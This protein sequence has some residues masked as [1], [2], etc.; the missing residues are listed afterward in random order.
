MRP[1]S[2]YGSLESDGDG[3]EHGGDTESGPHS[4]EPPEPLE[5][6]AWLESPLDRLHPEQSLA[7]I[8]KVWCFFI[9]PLTRM[10]LVG[11]WGGCWS[12]S[13]LLKGKGRL[14]P[15]MRSY[16]QGLSWARELSVP[17]SR[18]HR[19]CCQG[20]RTPILPSTFCQLFFFKRC[21][22]YYYSNLTWP[23]CEQTPLHYMKKNFLCFCCCFHRVSRRFC[24]A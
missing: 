21:W 23:T 10:S 20:V 5:A 16:L 9:P 4:P 22:V 8:F 12:R 6:E 11:L 2:S 3:E 19:Q 1:P 24:Q 7:H 15:R 13:S 14:L 17:C 18:V